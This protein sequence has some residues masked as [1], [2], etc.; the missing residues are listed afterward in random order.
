M[1]DN[2]YIDKSA[3]KDVDNSLNSH[4][5]TMWVLALLLAL[6]IGGWAGF[7][8]ISGAV[9]GSGV[10][11]VESNAKQV[12]H[13]TGG[14]VS[15]I[16]VD[17]GDEVKAGQP[18][19]LFDSEL[20]ETKL[21]ITYQQLVEQIAKLARLETERDERLTISFPLIEGK[22]I[23]EQEEIDNI[24]ASQQALFRKR[25]ASRVLQKEGIEQQI[26][27]MNLQITSL[28]SKVVAKNR[29]ANI[30]KQQIKDTRK[31]RDKQFVSK[32]IMHRFE[33]ELLIVQTEIAE[34][35]NQIAIAR[36][37]IS[38]NHL[39]LA[40]IDTEHRT[41]VL[42]TLQDTRY[43]IGDLRNEYFSLADDLKRIVIKAPVTGYVHNLVVHTRGGVV[44][45]GQVIMEIIPKE[46]NLI[47]EAQIA[48]KDID[49]I[50]PGQLSRVRFPS[51][52][53]KTT[54]DLYAELS[55]IS[56]DL[57]QQSQ[58]MAPVYMARL[59]IA[60]SELDKLNGKSL[61]PGMPVEVFFT[62][63]ERSVLSYLMKPIVD[64]IQ[65]SMRER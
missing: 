48:P 39:A 14:I 55:L 23:I 2:A 40:Q 31:L 38:G 64:Q 20:I 61:I 58:E 33:R 57:V 54:P 21:T 18:I 59:N 41:E 52:N 46:D 6:L 10:I 43:R 47:V 12:Q 3:E 42:A 26:A 8:N 45:S 50:H 22:N 1:V 37:E 44:T 11:V 34:A 24:F 65:H 4:K 15:T 32:E 36:Q 60:A 30:L 56:P 16:Y 62:T 7:Q 25:K 9:I 17:N 49:Q 5:K 53:Q 29:E 63:E 27:S 35:K 51:F 19:V 13:P 28:K